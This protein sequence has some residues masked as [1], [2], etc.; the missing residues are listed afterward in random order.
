MHSF[1]SL[2]NE[3]KVISKE[4]TGPLDFDITGVDCIEI[5]K[6]LHFKR[7]RLKAQWKPVLRD[8]REDKKWC[9]NRHVVI[10]GKIN[11]GTY[12][13][14]SSEDVLKT[15]MFLYPVFL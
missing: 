8:C 9:Y 12:R 7:N 1:S 5:P 13:N 15:G 4:Y 6:S 11:R 3:N 2:Y 14:V 10:R